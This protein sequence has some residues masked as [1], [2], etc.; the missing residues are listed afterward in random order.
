MRCSHEL[1]LAASCS[2]DVQ[3][4]LELLGCRLALGGHGIK[5]ISRR[6]VKAL[7]GMVE[8]GIT[9]SLDVQV[10]LTNDGITVKFS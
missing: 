10:I 4:G 2:I 6:R 7:D 3:L 1:H 8:R 9:T 5:L